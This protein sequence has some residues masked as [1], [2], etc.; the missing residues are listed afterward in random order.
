MC[1]YKRVSG[2]VGRVYKTGI[3]LIY[4][5]LNIDS[6]GREWANRNRSEF[7]HNCVLGFD[8]LPSCFCRAMRSP[9][10]PHR[11]VLTATI[12]CP[13]SLMFS[14]NVSLFWSYRWVCT[15]RPFKNGEDIFCEIILPIWQGF[16]SC[17][18]VE[19]YWNTK[20]L[21][22]E[23]A[24]WFW[25]VNWIAVATEMFNW[26]TSSFGGS[27]SNTLWPGGSAFPQ[28]EGDLSEWVSEVPLAPAFFSVLL[29]PRF[30]FLR[31]GHDSFGSLCWILFL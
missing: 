22:L 5:L 23:E 15:T 27:A 17:Q 26:D 28:E 31:L 13:H 3:H 21:V 24:A 8:L 29:P 6:H 19:N 30:F 1:P 9:L 7:L 25:G 20:F 10:R 18:D 16:I 2:V 4:E 14:R 11:G 12:W